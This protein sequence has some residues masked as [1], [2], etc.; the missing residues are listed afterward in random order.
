MNS[1]SN[2]GNTVDLVVWKKLFF[3]RLFPLPQEKLDGKRG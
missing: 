1:G 2:W 3:I